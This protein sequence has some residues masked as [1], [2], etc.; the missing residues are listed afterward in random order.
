MNRFRT[1]IA[2]LVV[3][4]QFSSIAVA[5]P[6]NKTDSLLYYLKAI[7]G[8]N[9]NDSLYYNKAVS[10]FFLNRKT[11]WL[12]NASVNEAL[13]HLKAI[14]EGRKYYDLITSF[15]T[16]HLE[17]DSIPGDAII[18]YGK[19]FVKENYG[20]ISRYGSYALLRVLREMRIP[21]RD[22]SR[23]YEGI[24]Y[25][26]G[27]KNDFLA[28]ND[29]DAI[30]IAYN[31][32]TGFYYRLG[33]DEKTEYNMLRSI[34]FL[35]DKQLSAGYN[36]TEMLL[37]KSGKV[38]RYSV[39]GSYL[40]GWGKPKEA[41]MY[42]SEAIRNYL[43][44][45]S[46]ML[47]LDAPFL[48]LQKA[49]CKTLLK[50]D[51]S[52]YFYDQA[53]NYLV[54]YKGLTSEYAH[55]YME[56]SNDFLA[57]QRLDS[58]EYYIRESK[59][60]K[61]SLHLPVV[62]FS[63]EL[64]PSYY[65]AVI[66]LKQNNPQGAIQL[67]REEINELKHVNTIMALIR[68]LKLL[69]AA[70]SATG[71]DSEG[72]KTMQELLDV[73]EKLEEEEAN[74]KSIS[75]DIE[76]KMQDNDI[77]IAVLN[78]QNKSNKKA[79]YYLYGI[80]AL[81]GLFAVT[82]G[83]LIFNKQR[84]NA[85]LTIKNDETTRALE[86]LKQTQSQLVQSEKM[87]SLGELTAGIAHEIQNPLNF[88]NNFSEVN[89]EL[90][91]EMNE[92]IQK[93]NYSDVKAIAK[94]ITDNEDKINYHGKRADAIVKG[95]LQHSRSS[96]GQKEPTDIN[97]LADEYLRLAYHGLRAKDKSFNAAMK[98]DYDPA[99]GNIPIIPQDIGRVILNLITNAFYAVDEKKRGP[100]LR[101]LAEG[102]NYEPVV[103][104]TTKRLGAPSGNGGKVEISVKD[105][106]NGIPYKVL[107]KIFQPFFT[108]KPTGQGTGLGLSLSYDIV[109]AHGGELKV[110]TREGEGTT[111]SILL[112]V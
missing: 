33:L 106:G 103:T 80:T 20:K 14:L 62:S 40:I 32:L 97:A 22:G 30:S 57:S 110:E 34:E 67:L 73:K 105:N 88:V 4:L 72:L 28:R 101:Q 38:N 55:Y 2:S 61:D 48:F 52:G 60:I 16:S 112:P 92:E 12:E 65:Y 53:F 1:T 75:F 29:S 82:L 54:L 93:G 98:T 94:D 59:Q 71:R 111:F 64:T 17:F 107:D 24:E 76:K 69:A 74:T 81:L 86:Q 11:V 41:E 108:T 87:A 83:F 47:Q 78:S 10:L 13:G 9:K 36:E 68:D 79:K 102:E 35:S 46:P 89:K 3:L 109:K 91:A 5:Q 25:F 21:F 6:G 49:R 39:F 77:K 99:I 44:L 27:L 19:A 63:G 56:R 90:L 51:S 43:A 104:V 84:S 7:K 85:R 45:D 18:N 50:S 23:I 100:H 8:N 31:V 95:M 15:F 37:G 66:K 42:L 96:S 58:A 70:Y 26:N